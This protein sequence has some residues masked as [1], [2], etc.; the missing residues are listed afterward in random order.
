MRE[1]KKGFT[2]IELL[3]VIVILA[4]I[5]L[6]ATPI[7]LNLIET[8]RKGAFTRSA[9]GVLKASKLYYTSSLLKIDAPSEIEFYCN[10]VTCTSN[11]L[12]ENDK[13]ITLDVDGNMGTGTVNITHDG[14]ISFELDN[15]TYCAEKTEEET[16]ITVSKRKCSEVVINKPSGLS[17][18]SKTE[19]LGEITV[20]GKVS[21]KPAEIKL[22]EFS[23]DNGAT[24]KTNGNNVYTFTG[25]EINTK[26]KVLMKVM[27]KKQ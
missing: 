17:I 16:T 12:D 10:N 4:V 11:E 26:Y 27:K 5:A 22:Y 19:K 15:G 20:V 9:E 14:K 2:L 23:I 21:N 8:S 3:A 7:V 13:N 24:W 1:E 18:S 6:I 25:L